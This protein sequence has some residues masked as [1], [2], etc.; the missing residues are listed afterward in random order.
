MR[1]CFFSTVLALLATAALGACNV[2]RHECGDG[3]DNDG[4]GLFDDLDPGCAYSGGETELSPPECQDG[5]DNDNDGLSDYPDDPGCE[6]ESDDSEEDPI[7][8]CN[9]GVDN[10]F[11]TYIDYP[12]DPGCDSPL[13]TLEHTPPAC[14]DSQDND[15]DGYTDYPFDPGC[16]NQLDEDETTPS[17]PPACADGIDNDGDLRIDF[18]ADPGCN[19][20]SDDNEFNVEVGQ[21]GPT[22]AIEDITPTGEATGTISGPRLNELSSEVCAGFGGEYAF[23][24]RVTEPRALIVS[25]DHPQTTLDTVV[26]VRGDCQDPTTELACDDDSGTVVSR[27]SVAVVPRAE[28]GIPYFIIVDAYSPGSLGDF[29]VTVEERTPRRGACN[30]ADPNACVGGLLCREPVAGS[31]YICEYE[32]CNDGVDND[33]DGVIDFPEEPGCATLDDNDENDPATPPEC[34]NGVDDD[35]DGLIDFPADP[36]CQ[37]AGD[38]LELDECLAGKP[39]LLLDPAT[40]ASGSTSAQTAMSAGSCGGGSATETVHAMVPMDLDLQSLTFSTSGPMTSFDTVLY[41]REA[42]CGDSTAEVACNNDISSTNNRSEVTFTPTMGSFYY[43]FVDGNGAS[44]TGN[45]Q[46]DVSGLINA[47]TACDPARP[48][49]ACVAGHVCR[50]SAPMAGDHACRRSQCNDGVDNDSD[51]FMD[52]P[53]DPGCADASDDDEDAVN[54][55]TECSDG[56]DNDSDTFIDYP[57][58]TGC[59]SAADDQEDECMD[60]D[61]IVDVSYQATTSGSTLSASADQTGTCGSTSAG[62]DIVH[63]LRIP[64]ALTTLTIDTFG[65]SFDTV[66]YVRPGVCTAPAMWC[67]D[68]ATGLQSQLDLTGV[69]ADN[70]YIVV[71][72]YGS[73]SGNYVLN[74]SGTIASGAVCDPAQ[75]ASGM[76]TCAGTTSCM[77]DGGGSARCM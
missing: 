2:T 65:S 14:S 5:Q 53:L 39:V 19:S 26:Y 24:Y 42:S 60:L 12:D 22:L 71:D 36:G 32:A 73:V 50:E 17:P 74:I 3:V 76:F 15:G 13:D 49:F 9:D 48:S 28:P 33:G 57:A 11:D 58:D 66:L 27:A 25:T 72:G 61:P 68:D 34:S 37:A 62:P 47:N 56:V 63:R 70:Y 77:D 43:V 69:A 40:G 59:T 6:N 21:C 67:N 10:D 52:Y 7:V 38:P 54:P 75:I 29:K 30:P 64:G 8:E 44:V 46:L 23:T 41:V 55:V 1:G 51:G 4:D 35:L 45:Y 16:I 31:G 18:P 20:A